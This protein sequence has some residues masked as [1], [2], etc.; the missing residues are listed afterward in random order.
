V[1]RANSTYLLADIC[2]IIT[3]LGT[4][5]ISMN[6]SPFRGFDDEKKWEIICDFLESQQQVSAREPPSTYLTKIRTYLDP[7]A[8]KSARK[9][10]ALGDSTSTQVLRNLE[11]SLRTNNIEWQVLIHYVWFETDSVVL[12]IFRST[13]INRIARFHAKVF[14]DCSPFLTG[15]A[16]FSTIE[17]RASTSSSTTS[18]S[19][20]SS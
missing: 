13:C 12:V 3:Y 4:F 16:S 8:S 20:S 11:I 5:Y 17:I 18:A 19:A 6:P 15:S 14:F 10:R 1:S 7:N 9:R 2:C